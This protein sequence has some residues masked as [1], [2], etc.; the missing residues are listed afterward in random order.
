MLTLSFI[1]I[2]LITIQI[3]NI[4]KSTKAN[5]DI[6]EFARVDS[7]IIFSCFMSTFLINFIINKVFVNYY[8]RS[9]LIIS[10]FYLMILLI[11]N[12]NREILIKNKQDQIIK[13]YQSLADIIGKIEIENIDFVNTPF[14]FEED[15]DLSVVNKIV[16]DTSLQGGRFND[17]TITLAQYSINKFFPELQWISA[18]DFPK[19]ELVFKGLQKPPDIAK[20]PGSDY[21]PTS[22]IPLGLSGEGEVCWNVGDP[23]D[24]GMSSYV[25]D[26]GEVAKTVKMPS[27][28][29]CLTLGSTGG[30]K[31]I[32]VNQ[33]VEI[34]KRK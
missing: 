33:K 31:A 19:R 11:V 24:V 15:H 27:A 1:I 2:L 23:K 29:Q 12:N 34:M 14:Q 21:R 17:N 4:K 32:W 10:F 25:L 5:E 26:N 13:V 18:V 6:L 8:W 30:G 16:L 3:T 7:L 9:I 28:P 20:Y 22:F